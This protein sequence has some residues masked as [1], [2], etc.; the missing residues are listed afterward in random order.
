M[1]IYSDKCDSFKPWRIIN[2]FLRGVRVFARKH[3]LPCYY[4]IGFRISNIRR[5]SRL[6]HDTT[7]RFF[8]KRVQLINLK[9]IY[10][11]SYH[12]LIMFYRSIDTVDKPLGS[13]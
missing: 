5:R 7:T 8:R 10:T 13:Y 12:K 4:A 11:E 1:Y 9:H 2:I 6:V 3:H